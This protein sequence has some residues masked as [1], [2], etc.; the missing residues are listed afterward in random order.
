MSRSPQ[1]RY[2]LVNVSTGKW[3]ASM[4]VPQGQERKAISDLQTAYA[5]IKAVNPNLLCHIR[6]CYEG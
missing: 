3:I 1:V 6:R 2:E 4:L 5:C